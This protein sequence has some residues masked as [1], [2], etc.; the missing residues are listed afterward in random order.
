MQLRVL[1][2]KRLVLP[3]AAGPQ[4][5]PV[6]P[7]GR[8]REES[9]RNRPSTVVWPRQGHGRTHEARLSREGRWRSCPLSRRGGRS[10]QRPGRR[11]PWVGGKGSWLRCCPHPG[12]ALEAPGP[13]L[14][15]H[16][17]CPLLCQPPP[18]MPIVLILEHSG[19]RGTR[20]SPPPQPGDSPW[21]PQGWSLRGRP[22]AHRLPP[23][24]GQ[25]C[26]GDGCALSFREAPLGLALRSRP[27]S[28]SSG[29][30]SRVSRWLQPPPGG[31]GGAQPRNEPHF[32][33]VT[34]DPWLLKA[35]VY[36]PP[37]D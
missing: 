25:G 21:S 11:A 9:E 5:D 26:H 4:C 14:P 8:G 2:Q 36:L 18:P 16:W 10:W 30:R 13:G 7:N 24:L 29:S 32:L 6:E 17:P 35:P 37:G 33:T 22:W 20:T 23:H 31:P 19:H 3:E 15:V 28:G 1:G 34:L 12:G 27:L